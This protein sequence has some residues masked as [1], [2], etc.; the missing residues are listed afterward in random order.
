MVERGP[1]PHHHIET[2]IFINLLQTRVTSTAELRKLDIHMQKSKTGLLYAK[3][4]HTEGL[5][6]GTEI[7]KV[8]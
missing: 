7:V 4:T 8:L 1:S 3:S 5:N 2:L 6:V